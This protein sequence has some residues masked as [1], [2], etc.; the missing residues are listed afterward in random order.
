MI[1]ISY[2]LGK[3]DVTDEHITNHKR[4][5]PEPEEIILTGLKSENK[6]SNLTGL[7][8]KREKDGSRINNTSKSKNSD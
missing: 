6:K 5:F 2:N 4:L 8:S 7:K 1:R 3:Q